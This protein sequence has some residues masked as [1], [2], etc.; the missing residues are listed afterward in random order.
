MTTATSTFAWRWL[1]GILFSGPLAQTVTASTA[2]TADSYRC[3]VSPAYSRATI[4]SGGRTVVVVEDDKHL[5]QLIQMKSYTNLLVEFGP[6]SLGKV[7]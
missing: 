6:L 4:L 5:A 1:R 7:R 2:T 3:S